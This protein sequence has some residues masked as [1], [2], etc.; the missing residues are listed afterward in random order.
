MGMLSGLVRWI[1][2]QGVCAV[3][4]SIAGSFTGMIIGLALMA[5]P[6][7]ALP[8]GKA[9]V[10]GVML[11]IISWFLVL[12][13]LIV[14]GR[15]LLRDIVWQSFVTCLLAGIFTVLIVNALRQPYLG[16]IVGWLVGF[17][18]GKALCA[19]C[20]SQAVRSEG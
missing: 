13:F 6:S 1:G 8:V 17:L 3:A 16:M 5:A 10:V 14:F 11:G 9:L 15:Y 2:R 18:I 19:A 20:N 4:G 12:L 7:H